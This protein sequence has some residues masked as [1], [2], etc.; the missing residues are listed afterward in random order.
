M[1]DQDNNSTLLTT[2]LT[3]MATLLKSKGLPDSEIA[4]ILLKVTVEVEMGVVDELSEKLSDEKK[5]MLKKM[6]EEGKT[7]REIAEALALDASEMQ[8]IE[9]R[10]LAA[11]LQKIAPSLNME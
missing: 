7:G 4:E 1:N 9:M 3:D 8:E 5:E 10:K 11:V 6:V 2:S